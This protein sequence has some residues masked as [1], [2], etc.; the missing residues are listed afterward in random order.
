[1]NKVCP[2]CGMS[3]ATS[4]ACEYCGYRFQTEDGEVEIGVPG[5]LRRIPVRLNLKTLLAAGGLL[6]LSMC[7]CP[8]SWLVGGT[9]LDRALGIET[10]FWSASNAAA[11]AMIACPVAYGVVLLAAGIFAWRRSRRAS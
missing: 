8:Q 9:I 11:A 2:R 10:G 7:I 3:T 6:V 1:M 5:G 4:L